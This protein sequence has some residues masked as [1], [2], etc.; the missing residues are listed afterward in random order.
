MNQGGKRAGAF[1]LHLPIWHR[2]V[3]DF[4]EIQ[5][6]NGDQRKKAH[7]IFPQVGI[8]DLFMKEQ[9]KEDGGKWFTFCPFEVKQVLGLELFSLFGKDFKDA[10]H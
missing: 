5:S 9:A 3:E 6:E 8:H 1:T 7:D 10:Y 2:D 4:L